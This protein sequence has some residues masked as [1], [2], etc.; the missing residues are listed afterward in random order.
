[1]LPQYRFES[2][3][4]RGGMGA[5]YKAV[6]VSLDRAV[7][8]KVL[9]G[10]LIGDEDANFA[11]RFK[12][13]ARTMAKMSHPGIVNVY[14]SGETGTGLLYFVMEFIDGTD[15]ARVARLTIEVLVVD[16]RPRYHLAGCIHLLG[17]QSEPLPVGEAI[18]L[19][20][21][22]CGLC[23]PDSALLADI[24]RG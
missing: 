3:L 9:P 20:F 14:D 6:Q 12:N 8:V 16:G 17:R 10:D 1:M 7:A 13:E 5:V 24:G 23:E 21:T 19:G 4:G 18:E 22:P 2:L 11:G 15:V